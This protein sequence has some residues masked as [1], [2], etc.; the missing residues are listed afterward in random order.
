MLS[1]LS[2]SGWGSDVSLA[3]QIRDKMEDG[4]AATM[5]DVMVD[6]LDEVFEFGRG[7][8]LVIERVDEILHEANWTWDAPVA[9]P[10]N[11][12]TILEYHARLSRLK[13]LSRLAEAYGL[14]RSVVEVILQ[15][16]VHRQFPAP[17]A[18]PQRSSRHDAMDAIAEYAKGYSRAVIEAEEQGARDAERA[19]HA[20][21]TAATRTSGH[22]GRR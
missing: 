18:P 2:F 12:R 20:Q 21:H 6:V 5:R 14:P 7:A 8:G 15:N 17:Q 19:V 9:G 22:Y 4:R 1:Y 16:E 3:E 10:R 11:K 13:I